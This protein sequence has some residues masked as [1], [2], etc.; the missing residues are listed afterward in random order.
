MRAKPM[1]VLLLAL[2]AGAC[3]Q[4]AS[5]AASDPPPA[6]GAAARPA[7]QALRRL[8]A[9]TA[10]NDFPGAAAVE[11]PA[12]EGARDTQCAEAHAL[13]AQACRRQAA[14]AN[15]DAARRGTL[16]DCAVQSGQA[17]LAAAEAVPAARRNTWREELLNA[18]FDRRAN[19][20]RAA[21]CPDND[22]MRQEADT[23]RR[24]QPALASARFF[25][26]TAR[27]TGAAEQCV[28]QE[29]RCGDLAEASRLLTPAPGG[30]ERW[31]AVSEGVRTM[32][33]VVIGCPET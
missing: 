3:D 27:L 23:L 12:C 31:N 26:A 30:D 32:Q 5:P 21:I 8:Q 20:A 22:A 11:V 13:K 15:L 29:Q 16:R 9:L 33:R 4:A 19:T 7:A 18:L 10:A 2:A 24:D 6:T 28:P 25:A 1:G 14:A 17:A